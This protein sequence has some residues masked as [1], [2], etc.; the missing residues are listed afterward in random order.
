MR[1]VSVLRGVRRSDSVSLTEKPLR[2]LAGGEETIRFSALRPQQV[3]QIT[4]GSRRAR[5]Q[6]FRLGPLHPRSKHIA[7]RRLGPA[8]GA[9]HAAPGPA[10]KARHAPSPNRANG[11]GWRGLRLRVGPGGAPLLADAH[12]LDRVR[13]PLPS[14]SCAC[15]GWGWWWVFKKKSEK[16]DGEQDERRTSDACGMAAKW[17]AWFV[18]QTE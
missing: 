11:R 15:T 12:S 18:R 4:G 3:L 16:L 5:T 6:S 7:R 13:E 10:F 9:W 14:T 1:T 8:F 2:F 17:C